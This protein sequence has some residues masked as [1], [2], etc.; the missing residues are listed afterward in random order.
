NME[1]L[2]AFLHPRDVSLVV[3]FKSVDKFVCE[4]RQILPHERIANEFN[5]LNLSFQDSCG[6]LTRRAFRV[7]LGGNFG[8]G[9]ANVYLGFK[10]TIRAV[11]SQDFGKLLRRIK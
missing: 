11:D 3:R 2:D 10:L 4:F 5:I 1:T 9:T 8:L 6:S 7:L